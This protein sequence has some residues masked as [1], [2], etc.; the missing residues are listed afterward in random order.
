MRLIKQR[1]EKDC[2][3]AVLAT[4][5]NV[6]YHTAY[7]AIMLAQ[8]HDPTR[9]GTFGKG[10]VG[11]LRESGLAPKT[12]RLMPTGPRGWDAVPH[13]RRTIVRLNHHEGRG[14]HLVVK[15]V[16]GR[17]WDPLFGKITDRPKET[18][19]R[20]TSYLESSPLSSARQIREA[21]GVT[22]R[23]RAIARKK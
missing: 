17:C 20:V 11:G 6:S 18:T 9:R 22:P 5:A 13:K 16:N 23:D 14:S 3:V 2:G 4:V 21:V 7:T 8:T 15:L 1:G 10:L 12:R 19:M